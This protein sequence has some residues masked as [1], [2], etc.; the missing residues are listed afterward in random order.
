VPGGSAPASARTTKSWIDNDRRLRDLLAK[1]EALGA[2]ALGDHHNAVDASHLTCRQPADQ[3][4]FSQVT[5]KC[6]DLT[7]PDLALYRS[8]CPRAARFRT[9]FAPRL[10][11]SP[12]LVVRADQ[13]ARP[14]P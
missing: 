4:P 6:E 10:L 1:L 11:V 8:G 5:T 12:D 9:M 2:A 13:H 7:R 14:G 3:R